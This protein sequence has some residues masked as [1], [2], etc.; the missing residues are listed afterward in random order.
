[1]LSSSTRWVKWRSDFAIAPPII[2]GIGLALALVLLLQAVSVLHGWST[3]YG[4]QGRFR[5]DQCLAYPGY[6]S[7]RVEC[8]GVFISSDGSERTST[9]VGPLG[10]FGSKPPPAGATVAVYHRIGVTDQAFP[11]E[12]RMTELARLIIGTVPLLFIVG[13]AGG[14]LAGWF[15]TSHTRSDESG[16]DPFDY[17]FPQR[18]GL[19]RGGVFW[20]IVGFGWWLVDRLFVDQLLGTAGLG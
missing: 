13:G 1:M 5:V 19:Q 2:A 12:G 14:W 7:D 11:S 18:F 9:M 6:I 4:P 15:L 16:R 8:G 10:S 3:L 17:V 20:L